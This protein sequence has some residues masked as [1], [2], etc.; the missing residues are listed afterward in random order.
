MGASPGRVD[1]LGPA[2]D[3]AGEYYVRVYLE[4]FLPSGSILLPVMDVANLEGNPLAPPLTAPGPLRVSVST[5]PDSPSGVTLRV[6]SGTTYVPGPGT[7]S[8]WMP[9][10]STRESRSAAR[11][12]RSG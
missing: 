8:D 2:G 1:R 5:A 4:H 9:L 10:D 7:W 11:P 12:L 3:I 6:R